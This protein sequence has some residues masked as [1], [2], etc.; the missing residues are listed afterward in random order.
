MTS[1]VNWK[2]KTDPDAKIARMKDGT[3]HLAYKAEHVV[4]FEADLIL[5]AEV[6]PTRTRRP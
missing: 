1:N 6:R 3:M 4:D 5:A 2:S